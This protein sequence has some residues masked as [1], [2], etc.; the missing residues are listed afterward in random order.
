MRK[1]FVGPM[2]GMGAIGA[3]IAGFVAAKY[4]P[5]DIPMVPANLQGAAKGMLAGGPIGAAAGFVATSGFG[6][7]S[8][9]PVSGVQWLG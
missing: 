2:I 1:G 6:G 9:Q 5:M 8:T 3:A 7:M 4:L